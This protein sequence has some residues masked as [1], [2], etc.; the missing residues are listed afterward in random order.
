M[1]RYPELE[2]P[3]TRRTVLDKHEQLRLEMVEA[4]DQGVQI[5]SAQYPPK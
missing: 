1:E 2:D 5:P 3:E 4:H